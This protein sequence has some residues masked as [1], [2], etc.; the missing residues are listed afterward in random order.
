MRPH[1]WFG[2]NFLRLSAQILFGFRVIGEEKIPLE[3]GVIIAPNHVS[4]F[5]PP[6]AGL[7][8]RREAHFLAK[9]E[10]FQI[11]FLGWLIAKYNAVPVRRGAIAKSTLKNVIGVL[12]GGG[13]LL[14]FPEGTRS[15]SGR[16]GEPFPGIGMIA[17]QAGVP[18]VPVYVRGTNRLGRSFWKRGHLTAF[19]GDPI[20]PLQV[21]PDEDRKERYRELAVTVTTRIRDLSERHQGPAE[22]QP[23]GSNT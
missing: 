17:A 16:V 13:A 19:V 20:P 8:C 22:A 3:G 11:W 12:R 21:G 6:I 18:I 1:Y 14:L 9:R 15:K 10:L 5:D 2:W 23:A 4:Y 7:A